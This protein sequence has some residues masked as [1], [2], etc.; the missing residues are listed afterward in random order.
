MT[1]VSDGL[2]ADLGHIAEGS[3]VTIDLAADAL[4]PDVDAVTAAATATGVEPL[5]LVLAGGEDHA[6]VAC[7]PGAVPVGWRVIGTVAAGAPEVRVDGRP[8][9][10]SAGWQSFD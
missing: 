1:D 9:S 7:F 6:L 8:W 5:S 2:L 10:G 3:G 4:R